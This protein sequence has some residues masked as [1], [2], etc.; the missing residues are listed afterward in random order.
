MAETGSTVVS[1]PDKLKVAFASPSVFVACDEMSEMTEEMTEVAGA[2]PTTPG[3]DIPEATLDGMAE[4]TVL[5]A[6]A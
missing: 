5:T 2:V 6:D 4:V 3:K 1:E